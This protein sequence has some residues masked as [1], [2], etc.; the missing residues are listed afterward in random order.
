MLAAKLSTCVWNRV[1]TWVNMRCSNP[2]SEYVY[3]EY[4]E[5]DF[6]NYVEILFREFAEKIK[7]KY[8]Q[9]RDILYGHNTQFF[10]EK[11]RYFSEYSSIQPDDD[12]FRS[13]TSKLLLPSTFEF[14][15]KNN[16]QAFLDGFDELGLEEKVEIL[17]RLSRAK[18]EFGIMNVGPANNV[19]KT[20]EALSENTKY[21]LI[22]NVFDAEVS[23][24]VELR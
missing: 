21:Q 4:S 13:L 24:D 5:S 15:K 10:E 3:N 16:V 12:D 14:E 11:A 1:P 2:G 7:V 22:K 20:I 9:V 8:S 23:I 6:D 18:I 19:G 17:D